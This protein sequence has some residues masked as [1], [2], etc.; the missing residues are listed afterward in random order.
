M[1]SVTFAR[2][3]VDA[4]EQGKTHGPCGAC[5]STKLCEMARSNR[6]ETRSTGIRSGSCL[7]QQRVST[8]G[9]MRQGRAIDTGEI[10]V[11][12]RGIYRTDAQ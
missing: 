1:A 11:K 5:A 12:V 6:P 4:G 7:H 3:D 8:K 2:V 10:R 9:R